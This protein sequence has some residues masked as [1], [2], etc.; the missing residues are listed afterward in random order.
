[1]PLVLRTGNASGVPLKNH[2]IPVTTTDTVNGGGSTV[3]M[4][5]RAIEILQSDGSTLSRVIMPPTSNG[6][7][8]VFTRTLT[9]GTTET[10][11]LDMG[12]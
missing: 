3:A 1:M 2:F 10:E 11:E 5:T 6:K 8:L 7:S 4:S 9:N 12:E